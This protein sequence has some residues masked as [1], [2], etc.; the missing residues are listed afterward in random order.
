LPFAQQCHVIIIILW[1]SILSKHLMAAFK[2]NVE[3][4]QDVILSLEAVVAAAAAATN[5]AAMPSMAVAGM[6]P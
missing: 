3:D 6:T 5:S 2:Y 1:K 4:S